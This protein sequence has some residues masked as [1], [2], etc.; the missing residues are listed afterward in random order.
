[1][2][3]W[4]SWK[5]NKGVNNTR[6]QTKLITRYIWA[7]LVYVANLTYITHFLPTNINMERRTEWGKLPK[8]LRLAFFSTGFGKAKAFH[9]FWYGNLNRSPKDM[10]RRY[11]NTVAISAHRKN[12]RCGLSP[13]RLGCTRHRSKPTDRRLK[14]TAVPN[15]INKQ[16]WIVQKYK[17]H[18]ILLRTQHPRVRRQIPLV[19]QTTPLPTL[20]S[21]FY[22]VNTLTAPMKIGSPCTKNMKRAYAIMYQNTNL[23][24]ASVR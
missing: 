11:E 22:S 3:R 17:T 15:Q 4:W 13:K 19:K 16:K 23:P 18:L 6:H 9:P 5:Y 7:T 12:R 20:L 14:Y 1:M 24:P 21:T 2:I 8:T 10:P